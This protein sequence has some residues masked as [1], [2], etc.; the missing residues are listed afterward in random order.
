MQNLIGA[1]KMKY[2]IANMDTHRIV[3]LKEDN[4]VQHDSL[5]LAEIMID[6]LVE[7]TQYT[8]REL[9]AMTIDE[10]YALAPLVKSRVSFVELQEMWDI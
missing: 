2:I 3:T 9:R 1:T 10:Y 4:I 8:R 7:T 5:L 6:R